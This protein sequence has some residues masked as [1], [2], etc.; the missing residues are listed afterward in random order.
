MLKG[1]YTIKYGK[2]KTLNVSKQ[3]NLKIDLIEEKQEH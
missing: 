2:I 1:V 3:K